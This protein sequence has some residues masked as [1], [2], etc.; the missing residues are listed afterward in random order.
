[1]GDARV[2]LVEVFR[3]LDREGKGSLSGEQLGKL[4]TR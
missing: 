2:R 3:E 1:M 4:L